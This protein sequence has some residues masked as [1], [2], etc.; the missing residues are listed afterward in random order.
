MFQR[1]AVEKLH[2][3]E[4]F[5]VL[6]VDFMDG[7]DVGMIQG[8]GGLGLALE[9]AERLRVSGYIVGKELESDKAAEL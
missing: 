9:A 2:G 5:A 6:V 7:A 8:R 4:R 3:D 1:H